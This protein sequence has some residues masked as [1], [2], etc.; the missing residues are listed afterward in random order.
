MISGASLIS[1]STSTS[2][3]DSSVRNLSKEELNSSRYTTLEPCYYNWLHLRI[4]SF[5]SHP[6]EEDTS[7]SSS[8]DDTFTSTDGDID[9]VDDT[10]PTSASDCSSAVDDVITILS[11][12]GWDFTSLKYSAT[13]FSSGHTPKIA[14]SRKRPSPSWELNYPVLVALM[15]GQYYVEYQGVLG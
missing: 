13:V 9:V 8:G 4:L 3:A 1:L 5:C 7:T 11:N 14:H 2:S 12:A 10:I 15:N 6:L